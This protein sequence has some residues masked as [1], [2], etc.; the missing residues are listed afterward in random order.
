[1]KR[2]K[3]CPV[4]ERVW[5]LADLVEELGVYGMPETCPKCPDVLLLAVVKYVGDRHWSRGS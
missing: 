2:G 4:C 5:V 3:Y 1:M